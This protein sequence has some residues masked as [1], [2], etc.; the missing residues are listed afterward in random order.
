MV[1]LKKRPG[2]PSTRPRWIHYDLPI[3]LSSAVHARPPFSKTSPNYRDDANASNPA[4]SCR[5]RLTS[6]TYLWQRTHVMVRL[7]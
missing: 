7:R 5:T 3:R 1:F 4:S 6:R 2:P